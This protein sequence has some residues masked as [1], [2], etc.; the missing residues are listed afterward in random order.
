MYYLYGK[1]LHELLSQGTGSVIWRSDCHCIFWIRVFYYF[2]V[3]LMHF[4][5]FHVV[6]LRSH[7]RVTSLPFAAIFMHNGARP[8]R[9]W[10]ATG[11]SV[12]GMPGMRRV[13]GAGSVLREL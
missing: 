7:F 9:R 10:P 8:T 5:A 2:Y 11:G 3:F 13:Q 1:V 4:I 12:L 6:A